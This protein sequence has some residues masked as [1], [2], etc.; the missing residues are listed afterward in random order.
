MINSVADLLLIEHQVSK[1]TIYQCN[2]KWKRS[3]QRTEGRPPLLNVN[4]L[5][6]LLVTHH[7]VIKWYGPSIDEHRVYKMYYLMWPGKSKRRIDQP[8]NVLRLS[9]NPRPPF[10]FPVITVGQQ[11]LVQLQAI[12]WYIQR[13]KKKQIKEKG[14]KI[15]GMLSPLS[16]SS[17]VQINERC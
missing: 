2:Q 13:W 7:S 11:D 15:R 8:L 12:Q 10:H 6:E 16:I 9:L 3:R 5:G 17:Q 1:G 4:E 14:E